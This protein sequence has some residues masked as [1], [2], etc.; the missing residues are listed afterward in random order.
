MTSQNDQVLEVYI[1]ETLERLT[2][3]ESGLLQLESSGD[4]TDHSLVH[5]IFRDAHSVKAGANLLKFNNIESLSHKIENILEMIR[6]GQMVPDG[7]AITV[8][9]ESV[10]KL[11]ELV[12]R[13]N[14][15][16]SLSIRLH[17]TMLNMIMKKAK[18]SASD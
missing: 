14:E 13:I 7:K 12:E 3:I 18:A 16:D 8:L 5:G 9:L 17:E 6:K 4:N 2:S 10:D 11:R 1:E 15:S